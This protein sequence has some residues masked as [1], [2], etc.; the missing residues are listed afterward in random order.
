VCTSSAKKSWLCLA[1]ATW[2]DRE[3][4]VGSGDEQ[5]HGKHLENE[6]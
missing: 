4:I 5:N 1:G 2:Q 6:D 3:G